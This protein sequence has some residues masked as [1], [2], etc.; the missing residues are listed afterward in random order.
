M[1]EDFRIDS[2]KLLFHPQR[3]A[4][5]LGGKNIYPLS[6]EIA[7]S[8]TCNHRC[9]FCALD[10]MEYKPVLLDKDLILKNLR[11]M[12]DRGLKSI[13]LAGEG[14]PLVNKDTPEII[15]GSKEIGLDIAMSTNGVLFT[16]EVSKDCLHNLTWVRFSVSAATS[17]TY[18]KIHRGKQGDFERA[19]TNISEAVKIK[20]RDKLRTTI[21]VQLLLI[22]ENTQEVLE[23]G[24]MLKEIGVDYYTVKPFSQ[25]P[26]S[27]CTVDTGFDYNLYLDMERQLNEMVTDSYKIYFRA[28]S[29]KK[30]SHCKSYDKCFGLPFFTYVDAN[31]Q[32]WPCIAF[33]GD[34]E[35][36]YGSMKE[37]SFVEIWEGEQRAK[38]MDRMMKMDISSCREL[39]RL[40]EINRYLYELKNPGEHVNFV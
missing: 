34:M 9:T 12:Y 16:S 27:I 29:M 7:P 2:H 23:L 38:V 26:K 8:G 3:V 5:W 35:L 25:H 31:A 13:V 22:P 17:G 10:Y 39:C 36:C 37:K 1:A 24:R 40:D 30:K 19:I 21:G 18:D 32:V 20:K 15:N 11:D 6:M 33:L 14:E 4:D 28:K